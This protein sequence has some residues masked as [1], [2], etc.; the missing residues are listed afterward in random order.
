M[1]LVH[2]LE[3]REFR[4]PELKAIW[5]ARRGKPFLREVVRALDGLDEDSAWRALWLIK[6]QAMESPLEKALLIDLAKRSPGFREWRA[7]LTLCQLFSITG[8]PSPSREILVPWLEQCF[9]D[10]RV[11]VRAWAVSALWHLREDRPHRHVWE[12]CFAQASTE[13]APSMRARL[14]RLEKPQGL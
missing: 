12:K 11:I 7:R 9:L 14:R 6:R 5:L 10:R 13:D 3:D 8:Y 2:Q 1:S 4:V